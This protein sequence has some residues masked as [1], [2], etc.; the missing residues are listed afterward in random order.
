MVIAGLE[1]WADANLIDPL[2]GEIDQADCGKVVRWLDGEWASPGRI[3]DGVKLVSA[4]LESGANATASVGHRLG[5]WSARCERVGRRA[6]G[7][8]AAGGR[9]SVAGK[10]PR[11]LRRSCSDLPRRLNEHA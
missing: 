8:A 1:L 7:P 5:V 2:I 9:R 6:R 3:F 11:N 4:T 10:D